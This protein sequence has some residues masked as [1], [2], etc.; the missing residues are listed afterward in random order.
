MH[1]DE[2]GK[3]NNP[4]IS[5]V[6][7]GFETANGKRISISEEGY[8][9]VQNILKEF[10]G[11][12]QETD[13]IIELKDIKARITNKSMESRFRKTANSSA[14]IANKTGFQSATRKTEFQG[15]LQEKDDEIELKDVKDQMECKF[16]KIAKSSAQVDENTY[17]QTS[18]KEDGA[19]ISSNQ[20]ETEKE[21]LE[22]YQKDLKA[23][24]SNMGKKHSMLSQQKTLKTSSTSSK[25]DGAKLF[26]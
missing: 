12:L 6:S 13:Y 18:R 23:L 21:D 10:Q 11:N 15:C 8:K 14:Q 20:C 3:V 4:V 16:K 19:S 22:T 7:A 9:S 2:E 5:V 17:F 24:I 1:Q 25:E 26:L